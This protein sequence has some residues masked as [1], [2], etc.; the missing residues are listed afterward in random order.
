VDKPWLKNYPEGVPEEIDLSRY[1]SI[2]DI[3]DASIE[4]YAD[5]VAYVN[6][7]KELTF[8]ELDR[9]SEQFAA[10]LQGLGLQKGDRIALMMPNIFQYPVAIFAALKAGLVIVN[11]NPMYTARELRHQLNDSGARAIVVV[12]NFA[13]VVQKVRDDVPVEHIVTTRIGD[14][15]G[16]PKGTLIDFVLRYVKKAVPP[17]S[18]PGAVRFPDALRRGA[19]RSVNR[20]EQTL[21]DIAFLQYTGGTTG[22][23]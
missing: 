2:L 17:F 8:R 13:H 18:L 3:Y 10:Y 23:A 5:R 19:G 9:L 21:D 14:L 7:D 6:F 15:L 12:E 4:A 1:S 22:V 16:F 20:V 11:T